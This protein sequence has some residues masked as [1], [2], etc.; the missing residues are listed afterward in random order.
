MAEA[1]LKFAFSRRFKVVILGLW[2]QGPLQAERALERI[3]DTDEIAAQAKDI[4]GTL[5]GEEAARAIYRWV[6]ANVQYV[7]VYIGAGD[8]WLP[9]EIR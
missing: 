8:S 7:R 5:E 1:F 9:L 2:P 6:C 3:M 4:A